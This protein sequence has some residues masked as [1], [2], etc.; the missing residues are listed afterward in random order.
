M[1]TRV[2][3]AEHLED[4]GPAIMFRVSNGERIYPAFVIRVDG[5]A[6]G[7]LN[8]CAHQGLRLNADKNMVFNRDQTLLQCM[9]H[10]AAYDPITGAGV[11]GP[12]IGMGLIR[13][14]VFERDGGIFVDDA[15]YEVLAAID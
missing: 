15:T 2:G 1:E 13:V 11:R 9:S 8:V 6:L 4:R 7:Y 10:G 5:N 12:C 14:N 3:S